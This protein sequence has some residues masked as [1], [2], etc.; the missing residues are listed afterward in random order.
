MEPVTTSD[1]SLTPADAGLWKLWRVYL[2]RW[3]AFAALAGFSQPV[4]N[5][6][7][8]FWEQRGYQVLDALP[9]GLTCAVV[10]TLAQNT[11]NIQRTR[12]KSWLILLSTW[13]GVKFGFFGIMLAFGGHHL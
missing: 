10:F 7:D 12:W 3:L 6:M 13:M 9:F 4:T 11:L 2:T 5:H 1:I 8:Q